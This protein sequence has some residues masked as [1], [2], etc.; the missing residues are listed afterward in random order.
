MRPS[1]GLTFA[2]LGF[3]CMW[4]AASCMPPANTPGTT[5]NA[6]AAALAVYP[7]A[8]AAEE[9]LELSRQGKPLFQRFGCAACHSVTQERQGL[10]GPPLAGVSDRVLARHE[11]NELEARRWLVKHIRDPQGFPSPFKDEAAYKNTHMPPN[12][13][14]RDED[15]RALVEYL[16]LLR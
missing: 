11:Y 6:N 4:L 3:A 14:I 9:A 5:R 8:P 2:M 12:S 1:A 10:M 13:G 15:L 16:W 7:Q